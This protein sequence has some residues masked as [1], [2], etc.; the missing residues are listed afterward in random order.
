MEEAVANLQRVERVK[1]GSRQSRRWIWRSGRS[2]F[3]IRLRSG[4]DVGAAACCAR[5]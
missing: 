3:R 1:Q 4:S 2:S 5:T